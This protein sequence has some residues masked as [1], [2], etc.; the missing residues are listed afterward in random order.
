MYYKSILPFVFILLLLTG[1]DP[2]RVYEEY[3]DIPEFVWEY[4]YK[5]V[6]E[7]NIT[8]TMIPYNAYI[9]VRHADFYAYSNLYIMLHATYP[10]GKK[11]EGRVEL[12]LAEPDGKWKGD[13]AGDICDEQILIEENVYLTEIG[14]YTYEFEQNMRQNPLP[15]IMEI[16]FRIEKAVQNTNQ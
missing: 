3:E 9:N 16:G 6:F 1:C 13:C 4:Q 15:G 12:T 2:N 8:D 14:K 7:V 10:S 5:P 11:N